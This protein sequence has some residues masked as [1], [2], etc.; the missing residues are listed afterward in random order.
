MV[1]DLALR[2]SYA[3]NEVTTVTP[4]ALAATVLLNHPKRGITTTELT[5]QA[6][7]LLHLLQ[8]LGAR[9]SLILKNLPW[10]M[11]EALE[12]FVGDRIIQRWDDPDGHI[13]TLD[14]NK[15]IIL[16]YYKNNILHFF[17]PFA[18]AG[19]V[20]RLHRTDRLAEPRFLQGLGVFMELFSQEFLFPR[21]DPERSYWKIVSEHFAARRRYIAVEGQ[22]E[23]R[24]KEAFPLEYM[25]RLLTNY[26]ESYFIFL[27][28]AERMLSSDE[29][30]EKEF[31]SE[32]LR[33]ADSMYRKGEISRRESR[34]SFFFRNA[35]A[36]MISQGSIRRTKAKGGAVLRLEGA[37]RETFGV[38]KRTLT[39]LLFPNE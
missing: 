16:D 2:V 7:F 18:L 5:K 6:S 14:E 22:N 25:A 4:S 36:C 10:A 38:Y 30:E 31:L 9:R 12:R 34:S 23:V 1:E 35:L 11:E 17:L 15:R 13:Y 37:G 8:D 21:E 24:V 3:I 19:S 39:Q 32:T 29:C 26:F 33:W 28:A 20:F 27:H